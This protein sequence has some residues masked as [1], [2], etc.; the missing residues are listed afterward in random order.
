MVSR[1]FLKERGISEAEAYLLIAEY[2]QRFSGHPVMPVDRL[3]LPESH[4]AVVKHIASLESRPVT[5]RRESDVE[6]EE[7]EDSSSDQCGIGQA[8]EEVR[9]QKAMKA[10]KAMNAMKVM[11]ETKAMPAMKATTYMKSMKVKQNGTKTK[12]TKK[13]PW[14]VK[15]MKMFEEKGLDWLQP[16]PINEGL[17]KLYP[18]LKEL[19]DREVDALQYNQ[20]QYPEQNMRLIDVSQTL[21]FAKAET[22]KTGCSTPGMKKYITTVCRCMLGQES[23]NSQ[24]IHYQEKQH[25]LDQF[26]NRLLMDLAGN[27]FHTGCFASVLLATLVTLA[28]APSSSSSA[29]TSLEGSL[30]DG[31]KGELPTDADIEAEVD[32]IIEIQEAEVAFDS[33]WA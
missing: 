12:S 9:K 21:N 26:S 30:G 23:L 14:A 24:G 20:V 13:T 8:T 32:A 18:G 4:P 17:L 2:T 15:H 25:Q 5:L 19:T 3:F 10:M 6:A 16:S 27:A 28:M 1:W 7:S 33:L 29:S 11:K 22:E 31:L